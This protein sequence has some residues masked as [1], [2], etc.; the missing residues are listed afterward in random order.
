VP[1]PWGIVY[2]KAADGTVPAEVFLD[3]CPTGVEAKIEAVLAAVA[4][5]PPP[6]FSGGGMWEAMHGSMTGYFEVR[7]G[8]PK[9][10]HF[11][12]FCLLDRDGPGLDRPVIVALTGLRKP[13]RTTFSET[14]YA[15]VRALGDDYKASDPRRIAT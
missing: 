5:A 15:E 13:F 2:Y 9:R 8:G 14:D 11:R 3:D 6:S 4:A 1:E 7:V 10:E 12:L